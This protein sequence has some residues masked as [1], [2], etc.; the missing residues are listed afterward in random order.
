MNRPPS[1][2]EWAAIGD[3]NNFDPRAGS[4]AERLLFN[5][6][7]LVLAVCLV[8]TVVLGFQATKVTL[9]ASF[10]K[11]VPTGHPFIAAYLANKKELAGLE[12]TLRIAVENTD[13]TIFDPA[14]METL[15]QLNDEIF[16]LP[17]VDR[18]YMKSLWTPSTR[19]LGVTE[20]GLARQYGATACQ[21]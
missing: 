19:W 20:E 1:L 2:P 16:L 18:T 11:M 6:R 15:R 21:R 3:G 17:G 14:Y 12:N 8:L 13:G 9:N 10:E 4:L 5:N 7:L